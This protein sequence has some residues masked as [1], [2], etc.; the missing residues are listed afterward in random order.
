MNVK[1]MIPQIVA[2]VVSGLLVAVVMWQLF[3]KPK[4]PGS[5]I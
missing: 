1:E 3:E 4:K 2:G 5:L